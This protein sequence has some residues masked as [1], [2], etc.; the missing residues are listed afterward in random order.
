[1]AGKRPNGEGTLRQRA[2]GRWEAR[3]SYVDPA[4]G[5]TSRL[6]A[7]G[8]TQAKARD[9]MKERR[10]RVE[11]GR[12]VRDSRESLEAF[13]GRWAS[14]TLEASDRKESTKATYRTVIRNRI[15]GTP[16]GAARLDRLRATDVE[17]YMLA[18]RDAGSSPSTIRQ[19]YAVL[20]SILDAAERDGHV[21]TN[22]AAKVDRPR[23]TTKPKQALTPDEL[24]A[25]L[26]AVDVRSNIAP[27]IL[28]MASTGLRRGEALALRWRDV[29]LGKRRLHVAGT[30]VRVG[31]SL[32]VTAPKT[33]RSR[34]TVPLTPEA[35]EALRARKADQAA[36]KESAGAA[37][38]ESGYIFTT[39]TGGLTEPR[40]VL[41]AV[42]AAA[43]RAGLADVGTHTFRHTA[44]SLMIGA[45]VPLKVVSDLLGHS[46]IA[47]TADI[48][49]HIAPEVHEG[50]A[51]VLGHVLGRLTPA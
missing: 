2:D 18:M 20:R 21:A 19:T 12:P 34:R 3:L 46:S 27:F 39:R 22:P 23:L 44:A 43:K 29:E 8:P 40:N 36:E 47:I 31:D 32:T 16:L 28:L 48:Y 24:R 49:G 37:W 26:A 17:A 42:Q 30:L 35:V 10:A 25:L 45:G 41:R 50:A 6:S 15:A 9:A 13:A 1:M 11:A 4:T 7:Y 38:V 5:K 33:E 14:T 51:D